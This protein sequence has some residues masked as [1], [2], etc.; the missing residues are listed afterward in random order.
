MR[1]FLF[2]A[3][4]VC[5]LRPGELTHSGSKYDTHIASCNLAKLWIDCALMLSLLSFS[6][7]QASS[8]TLLLSDFVPVTAA[9]PR[10]TPLFSCWRV[11]SCSLSLFQL[12][13]VLCT[14]NHLKAECMGAEV[15]CFQALLGEEPE[16]LYFNREH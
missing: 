8:F 9:G 3:R 15:W 4:S 7:H 12:E 14:Q 5:H 10:I 6:A 1:C 11:A 13:G 2:K 16:W